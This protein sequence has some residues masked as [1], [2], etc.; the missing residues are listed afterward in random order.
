MRERVVRVAAVAVVAVDE[1]E[2]ERVRRLPVDDGA[3]RPCHSHTKTTHNTRDECGG[4]C[5]VLL[6]YFWTPLC[7]HT[8]ET[9]AVVDEQ[10][11]GA[12]N[13]VDS[14]KGV[15]DMVADPWLDTGVMASVAL[16][17]NDAS[18]L[19]SSSSEED[20]EATPRRREAEEAEEDEET[21]ENEASD[22]LA[23]SEEAVSGNRTVGGAALAVMANS[24]SM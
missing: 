8:T 19:V 6:L 18:R 13:D 5:Q 7:K 11:V 17:R 20:E 9:G 15:H 23:V 21:E 24:W 22:K 4:G 2:L 1:P 10:G 16:D 12:D 3:T 14:N